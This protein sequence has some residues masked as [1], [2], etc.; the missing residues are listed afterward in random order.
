V[1]P[2]NQCHFTVK[3]NKKSI[4]F[5]FRIKISNFHFLY[6]FLRERSQNFSFLEQK[7]TTFLLSQQKNNSIMPYIYAIFF[8][9]VDPSLKNEIYISYFV[10]LEKILSR[11][12]SNKT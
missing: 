8:K 1:P 2:K 10:L 5:N 6:S 7:R 4:E 12:T 11:I 3:E 9:I